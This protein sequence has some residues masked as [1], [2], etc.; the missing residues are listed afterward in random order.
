MAPSTAVLPSPAS[1]LTDPVRSVRDVVSEHLW[2][3]QVG[4]LMRDYPYDS[5]MAARVLGQGY[6]FLLTAMA[7][8][9]QQLGL[10]PSSIVD[11]ARPPADA[12]WTSPSTAPVCP[13][14]ATKPPPYSAW[15][16]A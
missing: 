12:A 9:G 15:A 5:V 7:K 14:S 2:D 13:L 8:R 6:A 1:T 16:A 4:L 10:A 11:T 3:K